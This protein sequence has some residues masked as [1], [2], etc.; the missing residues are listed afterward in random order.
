MVPVQWVTLWNSYMI[1]SFADRNTRAFYLH[2]KLRGIPAE[3]TDRASELLDQLNG[4]RGVQ[5]M[6]FPPGNRLE[7]L[8]G[9]RKKQY[10]VRVSNQWRICF[11]WKNGDAHLV[12]LTNHYQ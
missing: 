8:K 11:V 10:S 6:R 1:V 2:G 7:K 4:A 3:I 12:E 9:R 5:D